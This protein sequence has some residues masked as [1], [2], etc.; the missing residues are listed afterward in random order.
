MYSQEVL[1]LL[2]FFNSRYQSQILQVLLKDF[3][4]VF[5][6]CRAST[7]TSVYWL[8]VFYYTEIVYAFLGKL[9]RTLRELYVRVL[10]DQTF[11]EW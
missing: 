3:P 7:T 6:H 9:E 10:V 5:N 8:L 11:M 4:S 1:N 2:T